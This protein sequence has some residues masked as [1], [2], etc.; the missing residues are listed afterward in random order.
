MAKQ[1]TDYIDGT[2]A[3]LEGFTAAADEKLGCT[4]ITEYQELVLF[5]NR[6][7]VATTVSGFNEILSI[8]CCTNHSARSG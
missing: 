8:P 1:Y 4:L 7:Q 3:F 6:N 2:M 5:T